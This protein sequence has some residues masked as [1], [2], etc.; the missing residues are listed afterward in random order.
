MR[1]RYLGFCGVDDSVSVE[2]LLQLSAIC[3]VVEWGLLFRSDR[4]GE[5]RYASPALVHR[6]SEAVAGS[7]VR[8]A[9]HLCGDYCEDVLLR[10]DCSKVEMLIGCGFK[11]FQLNPTKANN[12]HLAVGDEAKYVTNVRSLM[13]R[14]PTVEFILQ[15]NEE[16]RALTSSMLALEKEE[17]PHNMSL[18]FDASCGTGVEIS[19]I[20]A[21]IQ[22]VPCGYA[23]GIGPLNLRKIVHAISQV[24][25]DGA[26][27]LDME[28]SLRRISAD[29][30]DVFDLDAC[31]SCID[32]ITSDAQVV[33]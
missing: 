12:V 7:N 20:P 28:S 16:T 24:V 3:P 23:G 27:W 29:K 4:Q 2:A 33:F 14:F 1:L 25:G 30:A 18:L 26:V 11:R 19:A 13:A 21:P 9:A 6:L 22:G 8:L 31:R 15:A 32:T 17:I 10:G 5:P